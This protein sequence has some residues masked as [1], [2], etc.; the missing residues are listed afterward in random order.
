[1]S[2][3]PNPNALEICKYGKCFFGYTNF[4]EQCENDPEIKEIIKSLIENNLIQ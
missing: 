4:C 2:K 1:M 3:D